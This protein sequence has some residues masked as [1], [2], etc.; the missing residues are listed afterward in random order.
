MFTLPDIP[1]HQTTLAPL[2]RAARSGDLHHAILL[3]G[4]EGVGKRAFAQHLALA[5]ICEAEA[6]ERRP[7]GI[8]KACQEGLHPEHRHPDVAVLAPDPTKKT[9]IIPVDAVR[10]M[11]GQASLARWR[12]RFRTWIIDPADALREDAQNALLKTLEEPHAGTGFILVTSRPRLLLPTIRSRCL[13]VRLTPVGD[14]VLIPWLVQQGASEPTARQA[15]RWAQGRPRVARDWI[16]EDA[17]QRRLGRVQDLALVI[18]ASSADDIFAYS[19]TVHKGGTAAASE[20]LDLIEEILRD[21]VIAATQP[22][23]ALLHPSLAPAMS[24]AADALWPDGIQRLSDAVEDARTALRLNISAR[25]VIDAIL[26]RLCGE[27]GPA[28]MAF[29]TAH[30]PDPASASP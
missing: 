9:P 10:E 14:E 23:P 28:R 13:Q 24:R 3:Q 18:S 11:V 1:G 4:P 26:M 29:R 30:G 20:T 5:G 8:C 2:L 25:A 27:L 17:T 15:A 16:D 21:V 22:E 7:C 19:Q 6:P 12:G